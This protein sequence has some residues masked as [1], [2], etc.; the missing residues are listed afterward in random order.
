M[1]LSHKK[2]SH[3][4]VGTNFPTLHS[5]LVIELQIYAPTLWYLP[6]EETDYFLLG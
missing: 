4:V 6:L 1:Q 2:I 3:I 5:L